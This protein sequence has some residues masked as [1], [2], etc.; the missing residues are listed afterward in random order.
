MPGHGEKDPAIGKAE[1]HEVGSGRNTFHLIDN[2]Y[3]G[4]SES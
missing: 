4:E 3:A 2:R 1:I